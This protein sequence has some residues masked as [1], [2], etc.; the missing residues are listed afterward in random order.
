MGN[1]RP[2]AQIKVESLGYL[3]LRHLWAV[4]APK[5]LLHEVLEFIERNFSCFGSLHLRKHLS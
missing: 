3:S 1:Q 4:L 5:D 2:F